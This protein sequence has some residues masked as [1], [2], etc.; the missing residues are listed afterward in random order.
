MKEY[1]YP[2]AH[3]D[4]GGGY[5][6]SSQGKTDALARI[7]GFEMYCA[8]LAAGV[9]FTAFSELRPSIRNALVPSEDAVAAFRNYMQSAQVS[10]APVEE[11]MQAHMARYF[12]YR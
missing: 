2:G 6:I 7:A 10:V 1:V 4:V 5:T 12:T 3:S 8:A 9:P 11:M